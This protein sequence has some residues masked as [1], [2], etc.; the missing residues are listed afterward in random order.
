MKP[1]LH[2]KVAAVE[3]AGDLVVVA[4]VEA[5]AAVA[6]VGDPAAV[7]VATVAGKRV[8]VLLNF[9]F[10]KGACFT[11]LPFCRSSCTD[12]QKIFSIPA[13]IYELDTILPCSRPREQ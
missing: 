8:P 2:E 9:R 11:R 12:L 1:D 13:F 3:V 7:V 4:V 5:S 6:E 10:R